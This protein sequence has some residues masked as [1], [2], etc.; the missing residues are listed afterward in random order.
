MNFKK[1]MMLT[2]LVASISAHTMITAVNPDLVFPKKINRAQAAAVKR[3]AMLEGST[4]VRGAGFTSAT[5]ASGPA[6][7]EGAAGFGARAFALMPKH[8]V[9][10]AGA[11]VVAVAS[12][13]GAAVALAHALD[14]DEA[15][16]VTPVEVVV[17]TPAVEALVAEKTIFESMQNGFESI[18]KSTQSGFE[19]A[20]TE[21]VNVTTE[22]PYALPVAA[23]TAAVAVIG[24]V[25]YQYFAA[26]DVQ[27][28]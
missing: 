4:V 9:V 17:E 13:T 26:K 8:P 5:Q 15:I 3:G 1:T 22:Y 19:S 12:V 20:Q 7:A 28:S 14:N 24:Y 11:A 2:V 6:I 21:F 25:A 18:F 27:N 10:L 16:E 23:G